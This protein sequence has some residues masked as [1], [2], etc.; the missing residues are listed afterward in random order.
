MTEGK[1]DVIVGLQYGSEGKGK[2]SGL[3]AHRYSAGIRV[4]APNA[5]HTIYHQGK[6]FVMRHMPCTWI[7]SNATLYIGAGALIN[8]EVFFKELEQFPEIM[9]RIRIDTN[10][11][12]ITREDI[13]DEEKS[14]MN[15]RNGSTCEG[16]GS[17]TARKILR[18]NGVIA[19]SIKELE[20]YLTDVAEEIN[21]L[22][23]SGFDIVIE[24]TQGFGLC[25]NHA[26]YPM[27]TSRDVLAASLLSDAGLSPKICGEIIGVMRTYPIRVAGNSGSMGEEVSWDYVTKQSGS[28]IPLTESTTVTKRTRRV[29]LI[30]WDLLKRA[31]L[32]NRPTVLA[33]TFMDYIN[34]ED[35][36]CKEWHKLSQKSKSFIAEVEQRLNVPVGIIS[37]GANPEDTIFLKCGDVK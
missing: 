25:M 21:I 35:H 17:A 22:I 31:I 36:E 19:S 15:A 16:V 33:I 37:T 14:S 9:P 26:D 32:L 13:E 1:V 28:P 4:G 11:G 12:I 5:G 10:T 18:R 30:D 24:G 7:N 29:S 6:K 27:T 3:L 8:L 2:I 20:P 34:W 23:N